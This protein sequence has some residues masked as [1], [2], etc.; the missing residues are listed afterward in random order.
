MPVFNGGKYIFEAIESILSQTFVDFELIICDNAS[1]D[2]TEEICTSFNDPRIKYHR[3]EK[4]MGAAWNYNHV[5][6]LAQGKYF[7]WAAHDDVLSPYFLEECVNVLDNNDVIL[8]YSQI[9]MIDENSK[10]MGYHNDKLNLL[11]NHPGIRYMQLILKDHYCVSFFGLIRREKLKGTNRHGNYN[12]ADRV[13]LAHMGIKGKFFEIQKPLFFWRRHP[14]QSLHLVKDRYAYAL[15]FDPKNAGSKVYPKTRLVQEY[16]KLISI[17][18]ENID[19]GNKLIC[20]LSL[21]VYTLIKLPLILNEIL[22]GG[23]K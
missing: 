21:G 8:V 3:N 23:I 11:S 10:S 6:D 13:F 16:S 2:N 5:E 18:N 12:S 1:T 22:R 19:F 14:E 4:N 20:Y 9:E 17:E 15:W 7:K